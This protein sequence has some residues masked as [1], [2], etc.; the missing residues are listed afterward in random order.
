MS[1]ESDIVG[2]TDQVFTPLK[3]KKW[4]F[5][6]TGRGGFHYKDVSYAVIGLKKDLINS[7]PKNQKDEIISCIEK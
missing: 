1:D 3:N 4:L 2:I 6:E 5:P 7:Y